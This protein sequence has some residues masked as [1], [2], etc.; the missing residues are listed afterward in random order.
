MQWIIPQCNIDNQTCIRN[1]KPCEASVVDGWLELWVPLTNYTKTTGNV[2]LYFVLQS[3]NNLARV[4]TQAKSDIVQSHCDSLTITE[5]IDIE[6]FQGLQIRQIYK[7]PVVPNIPLNIEP[8]VDT[9]ITMVVRSNKDAMIESLQAIHAQ[10]D[11]ERQLLESNAQCH[12][13]VVEQ[14]VLNFKSMSSRSCFVFGN[15]NSTEWIE[16]YV[17]LPGSLLALDIFSKLPIDL[18]TGDSGGVWI[19]P[20]WPYKT[21]EIINS[22]TYLYVKFYYPRINPTGRRLLSATDEH[23][24]NSQERLALKSTWLLVACVALLVLFATYFNSVY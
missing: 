24:A 7:G 1:I 19:N 16:N 23:V 9:L 21:D 11:Q 10:T 18:Q 17:G 4:M 13:C 15:G 22:S 2:S 6:L 8:N 5:H 3:G 12:T 14:L 20:V